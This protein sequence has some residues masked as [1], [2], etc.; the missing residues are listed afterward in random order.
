MSLLPV[1]LVSNWAGLLARAADLTDDRGRRNEHLL[2]AAEAAGSAGAAQLSRDLLNRVD[3]GHLN[4]VQRG[5]LL[6][7]QS[8]LA[9][10]IADPAAVRHG[11]AHLLEAAE[12]F[13]GVDALLEQR[14]LLRAFENSLVT[15]WQMQGTTI[16]DL[17]RRLQTGALSASGPLSVILNA[18]AAHVLLPYADAVPLMRDALTTLMSLDDEHLPEFGFVGVAFAIALL[19]ALAALEYLSRLEAITRELGALR[20]LDTVLWV[21]SSVELGRGHPAAAELYIEQVRELRRA[22]GYEAENVVNVPQLAWTDAPVDTVAAV[23]ELTLAMGFGGVHS[24]TEAVLAVREIAESQYGPAYERLTRLIAQPFLHVTYLQ[25]ADLVESAV[26]SGHRE[27]A[28]HHAAVIASMATANPAAWLRGLDQRCQALLAVD[29]AVAQ[30]Y[31]SA[32]ELLSSAGTPAELARTHLL[33]GEWLRRKKRRRLAREQL[34]AAI[35]IFEKVKA[36]AFL[37]RARAELA[38]TGEQL[39]DREVV[40]GVEMAPREATVARMAATG[41]TN[42]EIASTLFITANTVD[43]HLRKV[44]QKLGVSSRR[45]LTERFRDSD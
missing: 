41:A 33:F 19:D 10:F 8:A 29:G 3:P 1:L 32:I 27:D 4:R 20:A 45:Q 14:A 13:H 6:V 28:R 12:H 23:G 31:S 37:R 26:R 39:A 7:A 40:V 22:I 9:M 15:E 2:A 43:Y 5:R 42:A 44:F 34:R 24:N 11:T 25:L 30:H 17:G 18:L 16:K 36:P 38:A 35:T 21:R